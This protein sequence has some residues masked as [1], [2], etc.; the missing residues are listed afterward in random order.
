M[1]ISPREL[2]RFKEQI[3][4]ELGLNKKDE[5]EAGE[6]C[7]LMAEHPKLI[8]RPIFIYKDRVVLGRP[9][10]KVLEILG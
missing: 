3:A 4:K 10:E 2:V 9:P 5:R 1:G 6:W 7:R 8:E